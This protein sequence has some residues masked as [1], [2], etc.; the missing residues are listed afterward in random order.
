MYLY[1]WIYGF[2]Q[3]VFALHVSVMHSLSF[4]FL[5]VGNDAIIIIG[6]LEYPKEVL[7]HDK[8]IPILLYLVI[9]N[10]N[11]VLAI[12]CEFN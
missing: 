11:S 3:N 1:L 5:A 8:M 12:A 4:S 7:E 2:N 10:K 9:G 6:L